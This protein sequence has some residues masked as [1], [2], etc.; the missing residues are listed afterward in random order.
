LHFSGRVHLEFAEAWG[1][2]RVDCAG[3]SKR[4]VIGIWLAVVGAS[5]LAAASGYWLFS[6]RDLDG[7]LAQAFA[8]GG[9]LTMLADTMMPEAFENGG[10]AVGLLTVLGFAVAF[11]LS[12][13]A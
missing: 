13:V 3:W 4:R 5:A 12:Q 11:A 2:D 10:K 7:V 1:N 6:L 8:A 9:L